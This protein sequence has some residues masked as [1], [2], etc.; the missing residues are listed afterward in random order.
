MTGYRT[1]RAF[2]EDEVIIQKS[3]F[4]GWAA[5][6]ADEKAALDLIA[7]GVLHLIPVSVSDG[8][9]LYSNQNIRV[10][11]VIHEIFSDFVFF[12]LKLFFVSNALI[13]ASAA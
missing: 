8:T 6:C 9:W 13:A 3:R 2:G 1:L 7:E 10:Y 4:I 11:P 5:P 12:Y